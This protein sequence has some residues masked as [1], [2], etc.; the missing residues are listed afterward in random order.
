MKRRVL[1]LAALAVVVPTT[2][3]V[4]VS[5]RGG[6]DAAPP[7][8]TVPGPTGA[9]APCVPVRPPEQP[10][11]RVVLVFFTCA[12]H[13]ARQARVRT[14]A[15]GRR[16][17]ATPNV[18]ELALTE[19]LRGPTHFEREAGLTSP[20]G[21]ETA[22]MLNGVSVQD[23]LA[24][25]EL[26]ESFASIPGVGIHG[27]AQTAYGQLV[28]TT[29]QFPTIERIVFTVGGSARRWCD[30]WEVECRPVSRT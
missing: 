26:D 23:G 15:A 30:L 12:H 13:D 4:V 1:V 20:F 19:L 8:T 6:D 10:G 5:D 18:L 2:V 27:T 22:G 25:V 24:R 11:T 17:P 16:V 21:P 28:D 14:V 9:A 3:A 7:P 29:F